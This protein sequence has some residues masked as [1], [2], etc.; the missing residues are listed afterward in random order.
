[1]RHQGIPSIDMVAVAQS[2]E[3]RIV[4]P[5]VA[6]SIPVGHP[7]YQ[8]YS[9]VSTDLAAQ[10]WVYLFDGYSSVLIFSFSHHFLF[11]F[12]AVVID[13]HY[14]MARLDQSAGML[15]LPC[16]VPS[17][18]SCFFVLCFACDGNLQRFVFSRLF[19]LWLALYFAA[20]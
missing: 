12:S 18:S 11:R 3:S 5:V 17:H 15:F 8:A 19:V 10:A 4:I 9:A 16:S 2:V 1:V 6:G 20:F 7:T 13:G 14:F